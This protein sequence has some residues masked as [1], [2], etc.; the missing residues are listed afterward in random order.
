MV[1]DGETIFIGGL[2]D[3]QTTDT[4]RKV[5]IL[6]DIPLVGALFRSDT[7][8]DTQTEILIFIT[9][10]IVRNDVA[11]ESRVLSEEEA[12]QEKSRDELIEEMV[13]QLEETKK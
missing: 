13:Q 7:V 12:A 1:K 5:P 8:T 2:L 4:K 9:P 11:L 10:H 3:T 6:G